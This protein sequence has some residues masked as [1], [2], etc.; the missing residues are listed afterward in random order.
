[1]LK[2]DQSRLAGRVAFGRDKLTFQRKEIQ[3]E[4]ILISM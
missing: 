4:E 1:M 3:Y 2:T